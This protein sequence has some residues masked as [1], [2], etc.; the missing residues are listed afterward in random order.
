MLRTFYPI[1][2]PIF[3]LHSQLEFL[4]CQVW[5]NANDHDTCES[6]LQ[7]DFEIIYNSYAW[8]KNDID[9]VY[10]ECKTLTPDQRADIREAFNINNRIAEL[11]DGV[12]RPIGLGSLAHVAPSLMKPLLE[13]F[14]TNLLDLAAVAG[15]KL[16][17]Y[18]NLIKR[19]EFQTCPCCGLSPIESAESHYREDNDHYLP[20]AE[21]P[22]A[23]VNFKNLVP[24]CGKCN[25]KCKS[26]KN[27]F[28]QGRV[29]FNP[30][31]N[32]YNEIGVEILI[33]DSVDL[34][35]EN[36][37]I[38]D[39]EIRYN[40]DVNKTATWDWLFN[41]TE[42]YNEQVRRFTKTELRTVANRL[43]RNRD[44]KSGLTYEQIMDDTIEDF[45]LE[46]FEDRKFLKASLLQAIKNKPEWMAVYVN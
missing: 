44:R 10:K 6:L 35:Y 28:E 16:E 32:V 14:Y 41:I 26:T 9:E 18:N 7:P 37:R 39:I 36:L 29:S 40:S 22:F 1:V 17:Y 11:C 12:F 2:D 33:V 31:S 24:L 42:R 43:L 21:Y 4:V 19:N 46:K 20:K 23:V 34:D 8:L 3:T 25:K 15:N 38:Q 27:P 13:K 5:C 45:E 30:F